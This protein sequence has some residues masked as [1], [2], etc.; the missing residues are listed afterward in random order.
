MNEMDFFVSFAVLAA[1]FFHAY[2]NSLVKSADDKLLETFSISIVWLVIGFVCLPFVGLPSLSLWPWVTLSVVIHALYF[3]MLSKSYE[4]GAF[5]SV[6]PVMRG[7]PPLIV[8]VFSLAFVNEGISL[9]GAMGIGLIAVGI[10]SLAVGKVEFSLKAWGYALITAVLISAY[11]LIDGLNARLAPS[12]FAF[13][14]WVLLGQSLVFMPL[15]ALKRGV[16]ASFSY[17]QNHWKRGAIG[18]LISFAAYGIVLWAM[19]KAPIAYV[20]ALRETSVLFGALIAV[21]L[22]GEKLNF[23]RILSSI[24]IFIGIVVMKINI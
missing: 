3:V 18:G 8:T 22:L 1:A 24:F 14:I 6:Y 17:S 19:T 13:L 20:S 23:I 15:V 11:T 21:W 16:K 10:L 5:A 4:E 9:N 12:S 7:L 2:W